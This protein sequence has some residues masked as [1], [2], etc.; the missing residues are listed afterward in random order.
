MEIRIIEFDGVEV[1]LQKRWLLK[2]YHTAKQKLLLWHFSWL[3]FKKRMPKWWWIY[4]FRITKKR[5]AF[6]V[7]KDAKTLA[8]F[9][10]YDHQ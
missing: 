4:S 3:D 5:R 7:W 6:C 9:E 1:F 8:V 10:I 2:Q